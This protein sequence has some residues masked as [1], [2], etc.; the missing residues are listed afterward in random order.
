MLQEPQDRC[1]ALNTG[2][3]PSGRKGS[4]DPRLAV[5]PVDAEDV[6]LVHTQLRRSDSIDA[7]AIPQVGEQPLGNGL[8]VHSRTESLEICQ[9]FGV[10]LPGLLGVAAD[11]LS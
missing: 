7:V 2:T 9:R 8:V 11:N 10:A 3:R 5:L 6:S 4:G 1:V